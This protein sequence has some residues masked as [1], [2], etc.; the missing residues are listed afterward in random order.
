MLSVD[1]T[2]THDKSFC[3]IQR[4]ITKFIKEFF[5]SLYS[6]LP[7]RHKHNIKLMVL[8]INDISGASIFVSF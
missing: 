4:A 8:Y 1:E 3:K 5:L 7:C 6:I 2:F